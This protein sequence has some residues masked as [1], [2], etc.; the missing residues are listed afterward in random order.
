M[1]TEAE[2]TELR[3]QCS[4]EWTTMNGIN[5]RKVTGPNGNSIFLPAAGRYQGTSRGSLGST[6]YYWSSSLNKSNPLNAFEIYFNSSY[7]YSSN[8]ARYMGRSIR[9]VTD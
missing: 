7:M 3:T 8:S 9:P 4:W 2:L 1:P 5:G 6:G